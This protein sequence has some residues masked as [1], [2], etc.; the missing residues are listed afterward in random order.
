MNVEG[1]T[2]GLRPSFSSSLMIKTFENDDLMHFKTLHFSVSLTGPFFTI[3]GVDE[4]MILDEGRHYG[5]INVVTVSPY[6]EFESDFNFI[7]TKIEKRFKGYKFIP[8]RLHSMFVEG[9]YDPYEDNKE[10][11]IYKALF[12]GALKGYDTYKM[13]GDSEFGFDVW[14]KDGEGPNVILRPPPEI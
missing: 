11:P 12:D 8:F 9:L 1:Q 10:C 5:A 6:K 3:Y 14:I 13:R 4:T 7:R 2:Y